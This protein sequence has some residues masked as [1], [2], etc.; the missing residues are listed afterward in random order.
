MIWNS[1][2]LCFSKL[3][4]IY[5]TYSLV[6]YCIIASLGISLFTSVI[7]GIILTYSIDSS[8]LR[9]PRLA[10]SD[11]ISFLALFLLSLL[12]YFYACDLIW[13]QVLEPIKSSINLQ[14]LP[15]ILSPSRN[16]SCSSSVH[17]PEYCMPLLLG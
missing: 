15:N 9:L 17:L 7:A 12:K 2:S 1:S 14:S 3:S 11:F 8:L 13:A 5:D 4:L 16:F 6:C 10:F